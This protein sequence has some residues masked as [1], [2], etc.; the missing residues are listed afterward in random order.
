M[1]SKEKHIQALIIGILFFYLMSY[2]VSIWKSIKLMILWKKFEWSQS[3][4]LFTMSGSPADCVPPMGSVES[5]QL[6]GLNLGRPTQDQSALNNALLE[7]LLLSVAASTLTCQVDKTNMTIHW[8]CSFTKL[9]MQASDQPMIAMYD[10][11]KK[12]SGPRVFANIWIKCILC[13]GRH[14]WLMFYVNYVL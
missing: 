1:F 6:T 8:L 9:K 12:M 13:Y 2:R 3:P 5:L 14:T 4:L 11:Q 10:C 7:W